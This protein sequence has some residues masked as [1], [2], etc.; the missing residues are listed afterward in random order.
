MKKSVKRAIQLAVIVYL[1]LFAAMFAI[2]LVD[3]FKP[4]SENY[5]FNNMVQESMSSSRSKSNYASEKIVIA[6]GGGSQVVDQKYERVASVRLSSAS[7]ESDNETIRELARKADAVIQ[8]ENVSGLPGSRVLSLKLGVVPEA[9][10]ATVEALSGI[11]RLR[12]IQIV[13]TDRTADFRALE[14]NRLSLEK[15]RDGLKSLRK[16]GA[17]LSDLVALET[18]ILEIEGQIQELGVSLGDYSE[19]NSFCTISLSLVEQLPPGAMAVISVA[20]GAMGMALLAELGIAV[21]L[22]CA[23]AIG[24]LGLYVWEK[25]RAMRQRED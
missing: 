5:T 10:D 22:L 6:Q 1:V 21:V 11:A 18:K 8:S 9:F 24:A 19:Q 15:T 16:T 17:D 13:K 7:F 4:A 25:I 14:A 3:E 23:V 20:F 2:E 12:G